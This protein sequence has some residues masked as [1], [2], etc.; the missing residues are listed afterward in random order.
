M[1]ACGDRRAIEPQLR[2][3]AWIGDDPVWWRPG[4]DDAYHRLTEADAA[5][6]QAAF[7]QAG[8]AA[9]A[10]SRG[11][12]RGRVAASSSGKTRLAHVGYDR[13]RVAGDRSSGRFQGDL[14]YGCSDHAGA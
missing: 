12:A 8:G 5:E 10:P 14:A 7:E 3:E 2:A 9:A 4:R 1:L 6:L 11:P 13:P